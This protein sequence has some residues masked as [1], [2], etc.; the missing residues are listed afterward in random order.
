MNRRALD[1]PPLAGL[2]TN[3]RRVDAVRPDGTKVTFYADDTRL[4]ETRRGVFYVEADDL[5]KPVR[6]DTAAVR[7]AAYGLPNL[8]AA[9]VHEARRTTRPT[10]DPVGERLAG[11]LATGLRLA[12]G[13]L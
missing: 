1:L 6:L 4:V 13:G 12:G 7:S 3:V 9:T 2:G 5:A 10:D 8:V 11:M